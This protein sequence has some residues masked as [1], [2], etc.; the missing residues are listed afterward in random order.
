VLRCYRTQRSKTRAAT[1]ISILPC[2]GEGERQ[3]FMFCTLLEAQ[4]GLL[5]VSFSGDA[6]LQ[7][8]VSTSSWHKKI[9]PIG[10]GNH[11]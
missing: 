5:N 4:N 2:L 11:Q 6:P 1:L 9:V 7:A 8:T 3:G 10:D